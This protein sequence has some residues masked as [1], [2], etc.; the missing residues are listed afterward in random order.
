MKNKIVK[1]LDVKS[2]ITL[3]TTMVFSILTLRGDVD[4]Q[5]FLTV[6]A[7]IIGTYFGVQSEKKK[8]KED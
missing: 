2:I 1:L 5:Q 4:A 6:F 3:T 8:E 7:A